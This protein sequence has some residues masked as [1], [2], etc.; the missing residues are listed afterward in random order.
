MPRRSPGKLEANPGEPIRDLCGL[1]ESA[2]V[3]VYSKAVA[4]DGFFGLA[5]GPGDGGPAIV[6][7]VWDRISVERSN[8]RRARTGPFAVH[9]DTLNVSQT[10]ED[11]GRRTRRTSSPAF[12]MPEVCLRPRMGGDEV[13]VPRPRHEAEADL[14]VSY[15]TVLYRWPRLQSWP[16]SGDGSRPSTSAAPARPSGSRRSRRPCFA[17]KNRDLAQ[18]DFVPNRLPSMRRQS[19]DPD[20]PGQR[21]EMLELM[22]EM[23]H[24]VASW[25]DA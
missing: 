17:R 18:P 19:K 2:G 13:S 11:K 25:A 10:E 15:R 4:S 8:H 5:V 16:V 9:L 12:L 1:L 3:K 22:A 14:R 7:N 21:A 6:V 24:R 20:F 23:R